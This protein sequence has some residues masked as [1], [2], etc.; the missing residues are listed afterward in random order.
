MGVRRRRSLAAR[1]DERTGENGAGAKGESDEEILLAGLVAHQG[2]EPGGCLDL[3][4][5]IRVQGQN[6]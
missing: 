3:I 4:D 5:N 2:M 6:G 1:E